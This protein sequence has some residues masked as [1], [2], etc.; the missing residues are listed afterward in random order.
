MNHD[1]AR[2]LYGQV[3]LHDDKQRATLVTWLA[4][5]SP[6]ECEVVLAECAALID[7]D[8]T[9]SRDA[10]VTRIRAQATALR[11]KHIDSSTIH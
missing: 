4:C 9:S 3:L 7:Q 11:S 2:K 10:W 5:L 1:A 6:D 8:E